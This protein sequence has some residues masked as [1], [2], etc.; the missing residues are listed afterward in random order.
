MSEKRP[1]IAVLGTLDTKESEGYYLRDRIASHGGEPILINLAMKKYTPK[2]GKPDVNNDEVAKA[3]G[4]SIEEVS[5]LG[6]AEAQEIMAK[7]A[8]K[9]LNEFLE[10]GELD[11]AIGFGGSVGMILN[12]MIL[13]ELPMFIPKYIVTTLASEA[14]KY[15][16]GKDIRIWWSICDISGGER[17][18]RIEAEVFNRAAAA[19]VAEAMP[20]EPPIEKKPVILSTQFGNTTPHIVAAKNILTEKGYDFI[21]FHAIGIA[22]GFTMEELVRSNFA[23]AVYDITTHE[24]IDEVAD[25]VLK[26]SRG[27]K[28]RLSA[29]GKMGIPHLVTPACIDMVNF[30]AP[31]T[32]PEKYRNRLFYE[33]SKGFITLM[34][35]NAKESYECGKLMAERLN[36]A[37][38]PV[39]VVVPLRGL[40]MD[41]MDPTIPNSVGVYCQLF[42]DGKLEFTDVPWW[43]PYYDKMNWKG[44]AEHLDLSKPNIDLVVVDC[45]INDPECTSFCA[46]TMVDMIEGRWKKGEYKHIDPSKVVKDPE[47]AYD[48]LIEYYK[49]KFPKK[50]DHPW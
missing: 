46:N 43:D 28:L 13:R 21:P 18:N 32:V 7:G 8:L 44:L 5:K 42:K 37:K 17:V 41:D 19:I 49:S 22:G 9:I 38:G 40:S 26:A 31:E 4:S 34:R 15:T 12:S 14:G 30:W 47:K 23:V 50:D 10:K 36:E 35:A 45:N 6:R 33:H 25:G 27:E 3:A 39:L 24:L 1:R 48:D 11:G 29:A 2:L 20:K 16:E